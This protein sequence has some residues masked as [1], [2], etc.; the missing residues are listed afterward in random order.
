MSQFDAFQFK[1][2]FRDYQEMVLS[3]MDSYL[4]D[5]RIHIVAAPGSGKTTLGIE[6]IRRLNQPALILS[7]SITIRNQWMKRVAEGFLDQEQ[8]VDDYVSISLKEPKL[9]TS[10]TYQGLHAAFHHLIDKEEDETTEEL[11]PII[12]YSNFDL[13]KTIRQKNI[14]TICLDEAH[15]L[16]SEWYKTLVQVLKHFEEDFIIIALTATPPYDSNQTEWDRYSTLCGE[17]DEEIFVPQLVGKNNLCPHQDYIYFNY[18]TEEEKN[19][20]LEYRKKGREAINTLM[21]ES[22]FLEWV[23][24]F[25]QHHEDEMYQLYE[26]FD[27]YSTLV[28]LMERKGFKISKRLH[29]QMSRGVLKKGYKLEDIEKLFDFIIQSEDIFTEQ[30]SHYFQKI[31]RSYGLIEY[32]KTQ[33]S[34]NTGLKRQLISSIGKINSIGEIARFE[35]DHLGHDLQMLILTDYIKKE[36]LSLI[37]S[38]TN[39]DSIGTVPVFEVVRRNVPKDIHIA[40]LTGSLVILP[41]GLESKLQ[42]ECHNHGLSFTSSIINDTDYSVIDFKGSIKDKVHVMTNLFENRDIDIMIGTKALLGE[43]WDSPCINTLIMASFVGSYMLSNQMRGRAIRIDPNDP[44]KVASIWH[45]A[46]VE[47]FDVISDG[48][49]DWLKKGTKEEEKKEIVSH[50]FDMLKR[51][52]QSFL[53]PNYSSGVIESGIERIEIIRPPFDQKRFMEFNTQTLQYASNRELIRDQW[54]AATKNDEYARIVDVSKI[55]SI[56]IPQRLLFLDV[57]ELTLFGFFLI[58]TLLEI[59]SAVQNPFVFFLLL[60][61]LILFIYSPF[62]RIIYSYTPKRMIQ[63]FAKAIFQSMKELDL[64]QSESIKVIVKQKSFHAPIDTYL[65]N[66]TRHE[67]AVFST[68]LKEMFSQIENPRYI[69]VETRQFFSHR[70]LFYTNS[71]QVPSIFA[72]NQTAAQVF[73]LHASTTKG[74]FALIYTK[75]QKGRDALLKAKRRTKLNQYKIHTIGKRI[76]KNDKE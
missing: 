55:P 36:L 32:G 30:I 26:H 40:M 2:T 57:F 33:L 27:E 75:S 45:L 4:D 8:S 29:K 76:L 61:T 60:G 70:H 34:M 18:P 15:H 16:R 59:I 73:Q 19:S 28:L 43:G 66:A 69:I 54:E 37:G 50:D 74:R 56:A 12:D 5:K 52:F 20:L 42:I 64:I 21:E 39:I 11:D 63:T 31:L 41:K 35:A 46:T 3:R 1:G 7:P 38:E 67:K 62:K 13:L 24:N 22:L 14:R 10:I 47:P 65:D 17:I 68:A 48:V 72:M 71:F 58:R 44:N 53:G 25:I 9:L 23:G 51:R 49:W 6:L